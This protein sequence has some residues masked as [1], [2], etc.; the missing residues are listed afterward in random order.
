LNLAGSHHFV[1]SAI[2]AFSATLLAWETTSSETRAL[3]TN[4]AGNAMRGLDEAL[5]NYSEANAEALMAACI[6]LPWL[7]NDWFGT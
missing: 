1:L 7:Q 3:A 5:G 6:I 2:F 4:Y